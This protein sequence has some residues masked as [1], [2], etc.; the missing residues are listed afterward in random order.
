GVEAALLVASLYRPGRAITLRGRGGETDALRRMAVVASPVVLERLAIHAGFAG[1]VWMIASLGERVM[2]GN[3]TL[4]SIES[5]CF[6]SAD[7]FG[8]AAAAIVAQRL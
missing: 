1:Y 8:I 6:L 2:A 3:Q 4:V 7:G 5:V